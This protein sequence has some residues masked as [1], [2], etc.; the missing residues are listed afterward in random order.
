MSRDIYH[1][2]TPKDKW[3]NNGSARY[4]TMVEDKKLRFRIRRGELEIELEG[5]FSYVREQYE[6]FSEKLEFERGPLQ[7]TESSGLVTSLP[8]DAEDPL[9]GI[10]Q[11]ST[12]G[13]PHLTVPA[14][15][16]SAKEA[17]ALVLYATHPKPLGDD[18][19]SGLLGASWKTTSGAI[20]RARASELKREGKLIAERGSYML[21]GAGVQWVKGDLVPNLR[22]TIA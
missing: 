3:Q 16:V 17:L 7:P 1:N 14:D 21:S 10:L 2:S 12:E 8:S 19:L 11:F 18:E 6:R 13:R 9:K 15:A 5:D 20:I 4:Q 22:K